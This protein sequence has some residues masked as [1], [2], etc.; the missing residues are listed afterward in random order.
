MIRETKK[1]IALVTGASRGIGEAI[2]RRMSSD[3]FYVIG[4][5][6]SH[7][8][9]ERIKENLGDDGFG[10]EMKLEDEASIGEAMKAILNECEAVD[11]IVNNAGLARDNLLIRMNF[12]EWQ[13]VIDVNLTGLYRVVKPLIRGMMKKRWGRIINISSVIG[14]MGNAGQSNYAASKAGL[15]GFTRSLAQEIGSRGITV[16]CVSPGYIVTDMTGDLSEEQILAIKSRIGVGRLGRG[17]DVAPVVAFL[18]SDEAGYITGETIQVN[19]GLYY[20]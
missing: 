18:A 15:E 8:G 4:T 9:V 19:G 7:E 16:N 13:K 1:K 11:V 10:I 6:T 12:E 5:A 2:S 3:Q 14:R 20:Q 17:E